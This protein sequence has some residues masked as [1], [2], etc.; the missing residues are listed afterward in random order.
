MAT[1][2]FRKKASEATKLKMKIAHQGR[3]NG[4]FGKHHSQSTREKISA[5]MRDY[6][7][8]IHTYMEDD[9]PLK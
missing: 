7:N 2:R 4:M 1:R 3:R 6:W 9:Y 5:S 8:W